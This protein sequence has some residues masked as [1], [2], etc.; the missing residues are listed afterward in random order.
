[1]QVVDRRARGGA[2]FGIAR[3]ELGSDGKVRLL[4]ERQLGA[5]RRDG[6]DQ[7][8]V[9]QQIAATSG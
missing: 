6:D 7:G 3:E 1:V 2:R 5:D 8:C 4:L 9:R